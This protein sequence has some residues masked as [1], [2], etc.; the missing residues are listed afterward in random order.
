YKSDNNIVTNNYMV[1]NYRGGIILVSSN[2]N[3]LKRNNISYTLHKIFPS[4]GGVG[5]V[6]SSSNWNNII[7]NSMIANKIKGIHLSSSSFNN[8]TGNEII[9]S[10]KGIELSSS[11]WNILREN[12]ISLNSNGIVLG[13]CR[14]N[15]IYHNNILDNKYSQAFDNRFDNYWDNGYAYGGNFWS[16]YNGYDNNSGPNQDVPGSDGI[17]DTNYSIDSDS[18]DR[19]PLMEPFPGIFPPRI[20]LSQGNNSV[21]APGVIL[22]FIIYDLDL[23]YV[24]YSIDGGPEVTFPS[25]YDVD[26]SGWSEG[27]HKIYVK[28]ADKNNKSTNSTFFITIDSIKPT[29]ILNDPINNSI[30]YEDSFLNFSIE[31]IN[32][33]QVN[34]TINYGNV[35]FLPDPYN[36]STSGWIDGNYTIRINAVDMAGNINTSWYSFTIDVKPTV[37]INSPD[38]NSVIPPGTVLDFSIAEVNLTNANYSINGGSNISFTDPFDIQTS[39]WVDGEYIIQVNALDSVGNSNFSWFLFTIDS[40]KPQIHL[41]SPANNSIISNKTIL[42]FSIVDPNINI[43]SYRINGGSVFPLNNPYNLSAEGWNED[44]YDIILFAWDKADNFNWSCYS[45]TLDNPPMIL[46]SNPENNSVLHT[47]TILNFSIVDTSLHE[48]NY[49]INGGANISLTDPFNIPTTGWLDGEYT[50]QINALDGVGNLNSSW[51]FFTIDSTKPTFILNSPENNSCIESGTILDF[52]I[53]DLHLVHAN[54]SVN[55]GP[56]IT[57]TEP[58][59]I[60]TTVWTDGNYTLRINAID[61]VGNSNSSWNFFT[62]DNIKPT[63]QLINPLNNSIIAEGTILDFYINDTSLDK[64]N[65]SINGSADISLSEPFDISTTGWADGDYLI[66]IN[67]LDKAGNSNSSW[68][69]F[70]IDSTPPTILLYSPGNNSVI[71]SGTLLDFNIIDPHLSQV[72]YSKNGGVFIQLSSPYD[73]STLGWT[74]GDYMIQINALDDL[75]NLNTSWFFFTIDSTKPVIVLNSPGNISEFHNGTVLD[76]L[77]IDPNLMQANYSVNGEPAIPLSDPFDIFT[78]GWDDGDYI[79]QINAQDLAGNTNSSWFFFTVN[80]TIPLILLNSPENNSIIPNST[81]L[82][83]SIIDNNLQEANY[84][85]NGGN[86]ITFSEPFNISTTG[87]SDGGYTIQIKV[88]DG[89]GNS[90]SSL[91]F[92]TIDSTKPTIILN[93]PKNNSVMPNGTLLDFSIIDPNL[94]HTNYSINGWANISFSDPFHISTLGWDDGDY[95]IQINAI[96]QA[97][98]SNSSWFIFTIDSTKPIIFVNSPGNNTIIRSGTILDFS[99]IDLHLDQVTYSVNGEDYLPLSEP[100]NISTIGWDNGYYSIQINVTDMAGNFNSSLFFL[101]IDS[102]KPIILLNSPENNTIILT[103][104]ILDFSIIDSNL[105]HVNYSIN[106][107]SNLS[108]SEPFNISTSGWPDGA[109]LIQIKTLDLA[110]NFNS[111]FFFITLDSINPSIILNSPK[112]NSFIFGGMILDFTVDDTNL[113]HVNYSINGDPEIPIS[114]PFN[115]STMEWPDGNYT[116]QINALDFAGNSN[117]S[118]FFFLI[119]SKKPIILLNNPR[120]N[121]VIK[122][123]IIL[124]FSIEDLN[125]TQVNYSINGGIS[126]PLSEPFNIST[127]GWPDGGYTIQIKSLDLAG[128]SQSSWFSFTFDSTQPTIILDSPG[129]NSIIPRGTLLEF[130]IEDSSLRHVNYSINGEVNTSISEKFNISTTEWTDGDYVIQ[131]NAQDLAGNSNSLWFLFTIDSTPPSISFVPSLNHSTVPAG[132]SLV[133]EILDEDV[134]LVMYAVDEGEYYVLPSPYI[135]ETTNWNDGSHKIQIKANDTVGNEISRWFEIIVDAVPPFVVSSQP[136]HQSKDIEIETPIIITFSEEMNQTDVEDYLALSPSISYTCVWEQDGT[137]L[138]ISFKPNKLVEGTS[139]TL[140]IGKQIKDINGNPMLSDFE[141]AF[142]TITTSPPP[143]PKPSAPSFPYW[144]LALIAIVAAVLILLFFLLGRMKREGE[145]PEVGLEEEVIKAREGIDEV[146]I[147]EEFS[148]GVSLV[149]EREEKLA[150]VEDQEVSW[151]QEEKKVEIPETYT[152]EAILPEPAPLLIEPIKP[153]PKLKCPRCS[154]IFAIELKEMPLI[155]DCPHCGLKGKVER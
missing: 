5:I 154:G 35:I 63:I 82:D 27:A 26:T 106:G 80:S 61:Q 89:D 137:I 131:I 124:D 135:I 21:I 15:K 62:V 10:S 70:T 77:I 109:Y 96:D 6:V 11:K 81:I 22:D 142:T 136:Q 32:L 25:P 144:I 141:L 152:T 17:G 83:F 97:G 148:E 1:Y 51:F 107:G 143:E 140:K 153:M 23:E 52:S 110:G 115:I 118:C 84:S 60:S 69:S 20:E 150:D 85:V 120:N 130:A 105:L 99:V 67:A 127:V 104:T 44:Y 79:V 57:F 138:N 37:I 49:S 34:Y 13:S 28:A 88:I 16:D 114:S 55:R 38:N 117:S 50:I 111:S 151:I 46:L 73:I 66:Q 65:Y 86:V 2:Q 75:G 87:W 14:Y 39:G 119:D 155:T 92:F 122:S 121:S 133:I 30:I 76:F 68:F 54:Y 139:Y 129:N 19:Y 145:E 45:F 100:Y 72:N 56:N 12:N 29:I 102:I 108:L 58:F 31:D 4:W 112:N 126:I 71:P 123:G 48:V 53:I 3:N 59:N 128:N 18:A 93:S 74:D 125:L 36:I 132:R 147:A 24:N 43:V 149:H 78:S 116:I 113:M 8:I 40:I 64:I 33:L 95:T 103:G 41:N 9:E 90:K 94:A 47:G 98:N 7:D 134:N 42:D 101:T 91:F 146:A